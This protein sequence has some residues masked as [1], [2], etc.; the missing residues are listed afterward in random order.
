MGMILSTTMNVIQLVDRI[1]KDKE[2]DDIQEEEIKRE[3]ILKPIEPPKYYS[4]I[5][6]RK[7]NVKD[8]PYTVEAISESLK[9]NLVP[10]GYSLEQL[11][12]VGFSADVREFKRRRD[13]RNENYKKDLVEGLENLKK[14]IEKGI[15]SQNDLTQ[16]DRDLIKKNNILNPIQR[17]EYINK[18]DRWISLAKKDVLS[19]DVLGD[20]TKILNFKI[21][22]YRDVITQENIRKQN[23][24]IVDNAVL[25]RDKKILNSVKR[26]FRNGYFY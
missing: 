7:N 25:N 9:N 2:K 15:V 19:P 18:L 8:G 3:D 22:D 26:A 24:Q 17:G 20:M 10:I 5:E 14:E 16:E 1:N 12:K 4:T 13:K 21:S 23:R 6:A 11:E